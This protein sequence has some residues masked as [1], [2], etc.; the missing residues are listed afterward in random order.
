MKVNTSELLNALTFWHDIA[1]DNGWHEGFLTADFTVWV[2]PE[3]HVTDSVATQTG[4][5][6]IYFEEA[7]LR[8]HTS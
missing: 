1:E 6:C 3:G 7:R 5:D 2:D 8:D 4:G